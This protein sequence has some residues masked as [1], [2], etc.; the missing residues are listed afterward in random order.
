[1]KLN[2]AKAL[3]LLV[4]VQLAPTDGRTCD[5][6]DQT[7]GILNEETETPK[8]VHNKGLQ[9]Y[10]ITN[11]PNEFGVSKIWDRLRS[12]YDIR[13]ISSLLGTYTV[14]AVAVNVIFV[15]IAL[16]SQR[17]QE[18]FD[19]DT[20]SI[21]L[22]HV[23]GFITVTAGGVIAYKLSE[24]VM[25][26]FLP[27]TLGKDEAQSLLQRT[28]KSI[29]IPLAVI[30]AI[31]TA[32]KW[33]NK[34]KSAN[35]TP[36]MILPTPQSEVKLSVMGR[37]YGRV[38]VKLPIL[39]PFSKE[40]VIISLYCLSTFF[41]LGGRLHSFTPS[42]IAHPGAFAVSNS[43]LLADGYN[44]ANV[45]QKR[46]INQIGKTY[47]CHTCGRSSTTG[48]YIAD[49]QPPSGVIKRKLKKPH[50]KFLLDYHLIPITW[51]KSKQYF[52]SHCPNCSAEQGRAI[53]ANREKVVTHYG[54]FR[55]YYLCASGY[56][57]A[58]A[59]LDTRWQRSRARRC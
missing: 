35:F 42:N 3:L 52:Y 19:I 58:R 16:L 13:H 43:L 4:I 31:G 38:D 6:N 51:V 30:A 55:P 12:K 53:Q 11:M 40:S 45:A 27:H 18:A 21:L 10:R 41:L 7:P 34:L 14:Q 2:S 5:Y 39:R 54:V 9:L 56:L 33:C 29:S 24:S 32:L 48:K 1:M 44:Y 15:A 46:L 20:S 26:T 23:S 28:N 36:L 25:G 49:H 50:I 57:L 59:V 17:L 8:S 37:S 22:G 47:G